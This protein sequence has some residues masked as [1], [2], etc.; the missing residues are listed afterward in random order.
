MQKLNVG[1]ALC[2]SFCTIAQSVEQMKILSKGNVNIIPIMSPIVY[3]S[4]TRFYSAEKLRKDVIDIC[5][6][7][8]IHDIVGAEP[9]G[10][11]NLLDILI[12]SPCTGNTIAKIAGGVTDTSVTMAVKAHLRNNKPVVLAIATNDALGAS[13]KNIGALFNTKN[14]YFV[15][16]SQDDPFS[17][18]NS[19]I[20]DFSLL[21]PTLNCALEGKQYQPIIMQKKL[22]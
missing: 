14:I 22:Q 12:V 5:K 16:F 11:K 15:P 13:A 7:N 9:I 1:Y 18:N 8:I 17:K 10:P 19:L 20:A 2:G 6:N 21:S 4:D 3:N